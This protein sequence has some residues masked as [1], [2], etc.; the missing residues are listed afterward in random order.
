MT[1]SAMLEC[2]AEILRLVSLGCGLAEDWF[3]SM[4]FPGS[5]STLRLLHYPPR[6]D[7]PDVAK[8]GDSI[9]CCSEHSD[10]GMMNMSI[11]PS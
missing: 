5:L 11:V 3:E 6:S 7:V 10:S 1:R 9:L 4:F 8:D 2:G